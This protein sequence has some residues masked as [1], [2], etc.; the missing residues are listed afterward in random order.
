MDV[1]YF[2]LMLELFLHSGH[3]VQRGA[4]GVGAGTDPHRRRSNR[5]GKFIF[6]FANGGAGLD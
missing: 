5:G 2:V 6:L 1:L 4:G 3:D